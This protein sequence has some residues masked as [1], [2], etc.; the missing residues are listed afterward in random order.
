MKKLV[1]GLGNPGEKYLTSKHNVGFIVLD[2]LVGKD[3]WEKDTTC[4]ILYKLSDDIE[5]IKPQTMMNLSG[6]AVACVKNKHD[7]EPRNIIVVHD[8]V[9]I[10][11]GEWKIS[12]GS[13]DGGHNGIKSIIDSINTKDFIRIRVGIA[14]VSIF[15]N[16][17]RPARIESFVLKNL[18]NKNLE[19]IKEMSK[20]IKSAIDMIVTGGEEKAMNKFN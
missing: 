9:D 17:K 1:V 19:K 8:D 11:S 15:G 16:K 4:N 13:G 12:V 6:K 20:D 10:A 2:E 5:Y 7:L 14:P 3:G 18:S